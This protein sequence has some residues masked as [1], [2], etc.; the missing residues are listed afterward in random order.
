MR[1]NG[2]RGRPRTL[3]HSI[4]MLPIPCHIFSCAPL[5]KRS[6]AH[7]LRF[8]RSSWCWRSTAGLTT[9]WSFSPSAS[10]LRS[11]STS[12]GAAEVNARRL[13]CA[14]SSVSSPGRRRLRPPVRAVAVGSRLIGCVSAS[15]GVRLLAVASVIVLPTTID[16]QTGTPRPVPRL[17]MNR[18]RGIHRGGLSPVLTLFA[19]WV[20]TA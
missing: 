17:V 1:V 16:A 15:A 20:A 7:G 18:L 4:Q 11:Q 8:R 9:A 14:H 5:R 13:S 2:A 12:E 6:V 10:R 19:T 3:S